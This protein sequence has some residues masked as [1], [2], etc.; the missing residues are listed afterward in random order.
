MII[1]G[2]IFML[3]GIYSIL[4]NNTSLFSIIDW[5]M[6]SDWNADHVS[7]SIL[8]FKVFT[9][10]FLGMMHIIWGVNIYFVTKYGLKKHRE[11][12]AWKSI[13]ISVIIWLLVVIKYTLIVK[14]FTFIPIT[15]FYLLLFLIPLIMTK[16]VLKNNDK[17]S[18]K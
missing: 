5:I 16:D 11:S 3:T 15:L 13:L 7:K 12:W 2:Y 4:F 9:W 10:D 18:K 8:N 6:D 1:T 14:H 17:I